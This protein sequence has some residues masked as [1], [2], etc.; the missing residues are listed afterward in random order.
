MKRLLTLV[1]SILLGVLLFSACKDMGGGKLQSVSGTTNELLVVMPKNLWDGAMGDTVRQFFG[2][3]MT[4]L[5]Q[6]EPIF[7]MINLP[8]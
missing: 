3:E 6:K 5:P 8:F 4:G 2:Q 7:D 1:S